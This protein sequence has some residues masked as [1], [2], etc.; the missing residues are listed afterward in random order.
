MNAAGILRGIESSDWSRTR[1]SVP[2]ENISDMIERESKDCDKCMM[3]LREP[4]V[5]TGGK[6]YD[7]LPEVWHLIPGVA[8]HCHHVSS[9]QDFH[10]W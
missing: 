8:S 3:W 9:I 1:C 4:E 2:N 10:D 5:I 7:A 6:I